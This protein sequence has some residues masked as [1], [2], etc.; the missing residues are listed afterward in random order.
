MRTKLW[1]PAIILVSIIIAW[2]LDFAF[3]GG[4]DRIE[5]VWFSDLPGY[6][7]VF[8]L[9]SCVIIIVVSKWLGHKFLQKPEDYYQKGDSDE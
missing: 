3:V 4:A 8:G 5:L 7:A 2:A 6:W 1:I 9:V